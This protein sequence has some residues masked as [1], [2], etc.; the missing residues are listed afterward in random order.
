MVAMAY[1]KTIIQLKRQVFPSTLFGK[2][3][4]CRVKT[5]HYAA[6]VL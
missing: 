4:Q 3:V 6:V 2:T 1:R 5:L